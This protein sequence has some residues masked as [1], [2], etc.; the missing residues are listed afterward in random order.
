MSNI[1]ASRLLRSVL[2]D[3]SPT[4]STS[5]NPYLSAVAMGFTCIELRFI[6]V[7]AKYIRQ[8]ISDHNSNGLT[9]SLVQ[10]IGETHWTRLIIVSMK[11]HCANCVWESPS[12]NAHTGRPRQKEMNDSYTISR[13][14]GS[15]SVYLHWEDKEC[16]RQHHIVSS[17]TAT[18]GTC[19]CIERWGNRCCLHRSACTQGCLR[20][21][22]LQVQQRNGHR[23]RHNRGCSHIHACNR[24]MFSYLHLCRTND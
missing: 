20:H 16:P 9:C 6:S 5:N 14:T 7:N 19:P 15:L 10:G 2:Q 3:E 22:S 24:P 4:R 21:C 8:S 18:P 17:N 12:Q 1:K 13:I 23:R 11:E